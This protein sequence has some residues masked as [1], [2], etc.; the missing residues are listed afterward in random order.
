MRRK[1][2]TPTKPREPGTPKAAIQ[3]LYQQ[4]GSIE[5]VQVLLGLKHTTVYAYA[6]PGEP[7]EIK[8]AQVAALTD[9]TGTA[10]AEYLAQR[11]GGV[12]LPVAS[13]DKTIGALT[14]EMVRSHGRAAADLVVA[15]ADNKLTRAEA[16]RALPDLEAALAAL[17]LVLSSVA[18][19][20]RP[21]A[22]KTD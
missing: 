11:A 20:A 8:F 14:A 1:A 10:A 4:K 12:F 18:E 7:D 13:S 19:V 9:P 3:R 15:L 22:K 17:A 21:R 6:D 5:N 2:F 16:A